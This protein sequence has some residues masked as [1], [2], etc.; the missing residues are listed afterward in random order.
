MQVKV[1]VGEKRLLVTG[2]AG[3]M[4]IAACV[5]SEKSLAR[6]PAGVFDVGEFCADL[7]S[8]RFD[9]DATALRDLGTALQAFQDTPLTQRWRERVSLTLG[10]A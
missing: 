1:W 7:S 4:S 3:F 8:T 9:L 10:W 6:T 2:R 5:L